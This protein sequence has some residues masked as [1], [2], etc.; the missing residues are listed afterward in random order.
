[1]DTNGGIGGIWLTQG[2]VYDFKKKW[3][4]IDKNYFYY[5]TIFDKIF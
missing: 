2:G 1:M 5:T 4:T 3:G